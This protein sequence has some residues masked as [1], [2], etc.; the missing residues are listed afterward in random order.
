MSQRKKNTPAL[1]GLNPSTIVVDK[2]SDLIIFG[3]KVLVVG[4]VIYWAYKK[5]TNRFIGKKEVSNYPDANITTDDAQTRADTIYN[6]R[7]FFGIGNSQFNKTIE[8]LS[9]PGGGAINY[10]GLVRIYNAFGKRTSYIGSGEM[11]LIEFL[12]DQF[13]DDHLQ[14]LQTLTNHALF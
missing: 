9:L 12:Q 11:D 2:G 8:A 5:Y 1:K 3:F 14:Q 13:R 7:S 4:G 10:N 6:A